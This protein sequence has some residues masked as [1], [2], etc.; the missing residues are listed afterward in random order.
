MYLLDSHSSKRQTNSIFIQ[1][2]F[3][4]YIKNIK[5]RLFVISLCAVNEGGGL[6]DLKGL[7][8]GSKRFWSWIPKG[9]GVK[10]DNSGHFVIIFFHFFFT[11]LHHIKGF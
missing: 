1:R 5:F 7:G 2:C 8:I 10:Q 3:H 4:L 9:S 6:A 11:P